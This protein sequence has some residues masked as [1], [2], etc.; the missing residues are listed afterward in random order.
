MRAL[1]I[2]F[3]A[4]GGCAGSPL[5]ATPATPLRTAAE[6]RQGT[7]LML[8]R[9]AADL[10]PENSLDACELAFLFGGDGIEIDLRRTRDGTIVLL[11]DEWIDR[12]LDGF[13]NAA[14]LSYEELLLLPF[15]DPGFP[16]ARVATLDQALALCKRTHGLLHLDVKVPGID[17]EILRR[18]EEA[19]L[20]DHVATVNAQ[21]A[22]A[23]RK[24]PRVRPLP[25]RGSL[26]HGANDYSRADV[27]SRLRSGKGGTLL[28]DDPR[29]AAAALG[30]PAPDPALVAHRVPFVPPLVM[31]RGRAE[32]LLS[33]A[34]NLPEPPDFSRR[35]ALARLILFYRRVAEREIP[36][37]APQ[38]PPEVRP[39]WIWAMG[40]LASSGWTPAEP[41]RSLILEALAGG[42]GLEAA[43][44]AAG[45]ARLEEAVPRLV[46]I[47]EKLAAPSGRLAADDE[48]R[49]RHASRIR[50]RAAAAKA[51]GRIG[52]ATPE[53][54][55]ALRDAVA[56]RSL[57][58]EGAWQ[59]LDGAEAVKALASLD[60]AGSVP[61]FRE[62]ALRRDPALAEIARREEIP[63][64]L[65]QVPSWWDFRIKTEAIRA[66]GAIGTAE[67]RAILESF[68][69]IP[70]EEAEKAWRELHWDAARALAGGRLTLSVTKLKRLFEHPTPAVR[71]TAAVALLARWREEYAPL[72]D[73]HVPWAKAWGAD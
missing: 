54:I 51:L 15:R 4:L 33:A 64:W 47:L 41:S 59:G 11:H 61:L 26:I 40:R 44:E 12:V 3:L 16:G 21:N 27:D 34:D 29:A 63:T 36:V 50:L 19:G 72:R 32:D 49:R 70:K 67:S 65:R 6:R 28:V 39:D 73:Q 23:L 18:I 52:K 60:P 56:R 71:R 69:E 58:V 42:S 62:A 31:D 2:L 9:G 66:L 13:G 30:R 45:E 68:L 8:H 5:P 37:R 46:E 24:D 17:A 7:A 35:Q 10:A 14:D 43:A 48:S 53:A 57:H 1:P 55:R 20:L 38:Q 22:E 25:S